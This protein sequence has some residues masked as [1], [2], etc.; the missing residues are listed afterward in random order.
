MNTAL[1]QYLKAIEIR[2]G[3]SD[4]LTAWRLGLSMAEI[5]AAQGRFGA[6]LEAMQDSVKIF[7]EIKERTTFTVEAMAGLGGILAQAGRGD[8]AQKNVE[9]ALNIAHEIKDDAVA[10]LALNWLGDTYFYKGDYAAA[11]QQYERALQTASHDA[12]REQILLSEVGIL[13]KVDVKQG[14]QQAAISSLRKLSQDA[15]SL[16]LQSLSVECSVYLAEAMVARRDFKNALKELDRALARAE[17][18]GLR[19]LQA[20]AHYT[21]WVVSY[22]DGERK[23]SN[24]ALSRSGS[25]A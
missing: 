13:A 25:D 8:E 17:K 21:Y 22:A 24:A 9:D 15:D 1:S 7:Q 12:N 16:G 6:A 23:G 18:L 10:S 4:Q 19:V 2:R 20:K 11:R 5:F 3:M 14:R